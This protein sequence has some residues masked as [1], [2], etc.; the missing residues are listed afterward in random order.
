[1]TKSDFEVVAGIVFKIVHEA[2]LPL[3]LLIIALWGVGVLIVMAVL[4]KQ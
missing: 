2:M 1:M 3:A 4:Y